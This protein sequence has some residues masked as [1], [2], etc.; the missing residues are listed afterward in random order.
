M[1]A[2]WTIE[3]ID[4][5]IENL[6]R[7]G[8]FARKQLGAALYRQAEKIMADSKNNYVPVDL[9]M[10]KASGYV[11]FPK[12]DGKTITVT[13]GYGGA[14]SNYAVY[15]HEGTGPAVGYPPYR[16]LPPVD[17]LEE[18]ARRHGMNGMGYVIARSIALHG[19][20]PKKFLERPL[21]DAINGLGHRIVADL[22]L[23]AFD[24]R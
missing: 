24:A 2:T 3:G 19:T 6:A 18:W 14:A 16:G 4:N 15:V 5:V 22:N 23:E 21:L 9:G 12:D 10:L 17:L 1:K 11:E 20:K 7:F 8:A 13:L